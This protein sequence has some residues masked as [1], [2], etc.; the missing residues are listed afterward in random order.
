MQHTASK[1]NKGFALLLTLVV[2]SVVLSIGLSLI[3]I[4]LKQLVLSGIGRD[5]E[6]ALHAAY[7]GTECARYWRFDSGTELITGTAPVLTECFGSGSITAESPGHEEVITYVHR[8]KYEQ[9]WG[10]FGDRRCTQMDIYL[11][12]A[13]AADA[14]TPGTNV[15]YL[16]PETDTNVV[17]TAKKICTYIIS[18][19][20]NRACIDLDSPRTVE[21]EVVLSQ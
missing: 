13:K 3:D 7:A 5:A 20:Y 9:T 1:Q 6:I 12:D 2:V 19:G 18:R 21:H 8:A 17:C 14:A 15:S 11:F 10:D 16:V 4:T